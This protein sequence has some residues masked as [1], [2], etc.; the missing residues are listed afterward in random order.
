[1][2]VER[3]TIA[4]V[5][6]LVG[7][8]SVEQPHDEETLATETTE[9]AVWTAC[10][11]S[12]AGQGWENHPIPQ[13]TQ[14][15]NGIVTASFS[16]KT[17]VP[18]WLDG[19][20]GFANGKVD[21]FT[22]LGPTVRLTTDGHVEARDGSGYR[23]NLSYLYQTGSPYIVTM[24]IDM[25]NKRYDVYIRRPT[26][27]APGTQIALGYAFRSEQSTLGRLDTLAHFVD[28]PT[29]RMVVCDLDLQPEVCLGAY[30]GWVA[31]PFPTQS[32]VFQAVFDATPTSTGG[33]T[34]I[35]AVAGFARLSPHAFPDLA[36]NI[37][38]NLDGFIDAR[39]GATYTAQDAVPY[40]LG[41]TYRFYFHFDHV[42]KR[43]SAS[44][45]DRSSRQ[46]LGT[47]AQQLSYRTEQAQTIS[48]GW[49]GAFVDA[50][51]D[52]SPGCCLQTCNLTVWS[53]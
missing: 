27:Q 52:G 15:D 53:Y 6:A 46:Y 9:V 34:T 21:A 38:F 11:E 17:L 43:Y 41:T 22:D 4:M 2:S 36:A 49:Q 16:L 12:R 18:E 19:V 1:M 50:H 24:R 42:A 26:E 20:I 48:L 39:D 8:A 40:A 7:C 25:W 44:V 23:A 47:I 37:R 28:S 31:L 10:G 32:G 51:P 33:A 14:G 35:D 30:P 3:I 5:A 45:F 13:Q 29:G